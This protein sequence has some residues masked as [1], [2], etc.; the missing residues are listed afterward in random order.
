MDFSLRKA[1]ADDIEFLVS[2]RD[3]TMKEHLTAMEMPTTR[4]AY[5]ER[6]MNCF[7][8]AQIVE[9]GG[10]RAGLFKPTFLADRHQWYV[11]QIQ[12]HP[13]YQNGHIGGR[14]LSQLIDKA[15]KEDASV[16]L[17][18]LKKNPAQQ[19]YYR[20]GFEQVG[21][22]AVEYELELKP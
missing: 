14:L 3:I 16:G 21:E 19:L 10:C 22:T 7:E 2:L 20:L 9:V 13:D 5:L 17:S 18:V 4:E 11:V 6:V 8:D 12:I 1:G 15:R